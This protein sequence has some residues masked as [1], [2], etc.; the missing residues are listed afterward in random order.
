MSHQ[1]KPKRTNQVVTNTARAKRSKGSNSQGSLTGTN[2]NS[3]TRST[4]QTAAKTKH[5][6]ANKTSFSDLPDEVQLMIGQSLTQHQLTV[7]VRICRTWKGLFWPLLWKHVEDSA[8]RKTRHW[9]PNRDSA[10]LACIERGYL[11]TNC[12]MIHSLR[13]ELSDM[14]F[15]DLQTL[16]QLPSTFPQLRSVELIGAVGS[17]IEIARFL[18]RGSPAGWK[19]II[20]RANHPEISPRFGKESAKEVLKHAATLEVL[21]VE[22]AWCLSSTEIQ[23]LLCGLPKLKEI[24]VI[25]AVQLYVPP[26]PELKASDLVASRWACKNLEVFGC[27]IGDIPRPKPK[28]KGYQQSIDLQRQVCAQLG[29]LHKLRELILRSPYPIYSARNPQRS[30][31]HQ[32][33]SCLALSLESGLDLLHN[34][35][36][37]RKVGLE[38]MDVDIGNQKEQ[39]WVKEH[40]PHATV[41]Y[42]KNPE[43]G[44][45]IRAYDPFDD[46]DASANDGNISSGYNSNDSHD[47][48][49]SRDSND[50]I[51]QRIIAAI[52]DD[53]Y[54]ADEYDPDWE[55]NN[56]YANLYGTY[57]ADYGGF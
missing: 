11:K 30:Y 4:V 35:K 7:C 45:R 33:H 9:S 13:L 47:S 38:D 18:R 26:D 31:E 43:L 17:D 16:R 15:K 50:S 57:D 51:R 1:E 28:T 14:D 21:R 19:Q 29:R 25:G 46:Y 39:A 27:S 12:H 2:K 37:L 48:N 49:D 34:L 44:P 41:W 10:L 40:W 32:S 56:Y 6:N 42:P 23:E 52:E 24:Y 36:D 22:G 8:S 20:F 5:N 53:Y 3:N 55:A 54:G